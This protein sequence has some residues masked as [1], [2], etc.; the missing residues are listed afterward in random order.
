MVVDGN[1]EL[2]TTGERWN[3]GHKGRYSVIGAEKDVLGRPRI[4]AANE[5][6]RLWGGYLLFAAAER[7]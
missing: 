2:R 1:S 6:S 4:V 3:A 7:S 5:A